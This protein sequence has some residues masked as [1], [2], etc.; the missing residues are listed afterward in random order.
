VYYTGI[1]DMYSVT[2]GKKMDHFDLM[3]KA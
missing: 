3:E 1:V 2:S